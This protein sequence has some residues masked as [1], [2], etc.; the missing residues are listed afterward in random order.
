M[1]A[2]LWGVP[3]S[4]VRYT[5]TLP[6]SNPYSP[7]FSRGFSSKLFVKGISFST[8]EET[9][10]KVFSTFGEVI[11]T[12]IIMNKTRNR[13]KGYGYVTFAEEDDAEKALIGTNGK[14]ID[15]RAVYV[16]K[17]RPT[18]FSRK[19]WPTPT[20]REP[21]HPEDSTPGT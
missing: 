13:S 19:P 3:R 17:V 5:K 9:L 8:T 14:I 4:F 6:I 18:K 7:I 1:A 20:A 10:A 16:D 11:E 15:G 21:S 2:S 12:N